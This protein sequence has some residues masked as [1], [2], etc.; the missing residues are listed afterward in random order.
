MTSWT[1][2][3][4]AQDASEPA[5]QQ[6]LAQLCE[7]YWYPLYAFARRSG[8]APHDAEDVT[9][10]FFSELL[11]KGYLGT[12]AANKGRLRSFLMVS[13]KHYLSKWRRHARAEKRGGGKAL[14]SIDQQ[15]AEQRY[16]FEPSDD[17]S[18]EILYDR[19]WAMSLM[20]HSRKRLAREYA[21]RGK[22][23]LFDALGG[24]LSPNKPDQPHAEVAEQ[25]DMSEDNV[26][27]SASR[28]RKRYKAI[29]IEEITQTVHS[30][31]EVS[32]E[33]VHLFTSFSS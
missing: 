32:S 20:Q 3:C 9:Q 16:Q 1:L 12:V 7:L 25:L 14:I 15:S 23:D 5:A 31:D 2:V 10:G 27:Q 6:A 21:E 30:E 8:C 4:Q 11:A 26:R 18:P 19:H 22:S 17:L 33:L 28:M 29:L 24:A 13:M